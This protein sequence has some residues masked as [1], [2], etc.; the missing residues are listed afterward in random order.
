MSDQLA[1]VVGEDVKTIKDI[2]DIEEIE[3][4]DDHFENLSPSSPAFNDPK[5]QA[6]KHIIDTTPNEADQI[7]AIS[8]VRSWFRGED[9]STSYEAI[10]SY[11]AGTLDLEA[12]VR[13]ITSPTEQAHT[14]ASNGRQVDE[15]PAS[16]TESE[17]TIEGGLF[18]LWYSVLHTAKKIPWRDTV[19]QD[20]LLAVV[21]A[22]ATQWETRVLPMIGITTRETWNDSPGCGAGYSVPEIHAWTNV[23]YFVAR[24]TA[25][26]LADFWLFAIWAMRP[27][28]EET[29][30]LSIADPVEVSELMVLD[31]NIPAAAVWAIVLGKKLCDREEDL[32]PESENYGDPAGGGDLWKGKSEFSKARYEFWL[33]RFQ[34]LGKDERLS[35]ETKDIIKEVVSAMEEVMQ[36]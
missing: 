26:E 3:N 36:C 23:N 11:M 1:N 21:R 33:K 35:Q 19:A 4:S 16:E 9:G 6:I 30:E 14:S 18:N 17:P 7:D 20:K 29:P 31:A 10:K 32:T 24:L 22:L 8:N 13:I 28:L 2:E 15:L 34:E 27:A 5:K 12:L 25:T